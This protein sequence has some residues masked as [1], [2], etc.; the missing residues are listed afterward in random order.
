MVTLN[1]YKA[2]SMFLK[3]PGTIFKMANCCLNMNISG[4]YLSSNESITMERYQES[5]HR[6][7]RQ[8][9]YYCPPEIT[10]RAA[11]AFPWIWISV[12]EIS[13][14]CLWAVQLPLVW[15]PGPIPLTAQLQL[16][17]PWA[18]KGD[19]QIS[20]LLYIPKWRV[21]SELFK[22]ISFV[23]QWCKPNLYCGEE[24]LSGTSDNI[25]ITSSMTLK[26]CA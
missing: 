6:Y 7:T 13:S 17:A 25:Q 23:K 20:I 19:C 8:S 14:A 4:P 2:I 15:I 10:R 24:N 21:S 18:K 12:L 5:A 16:V 22:E 26:S 11:A 9:I 1:F 3:L